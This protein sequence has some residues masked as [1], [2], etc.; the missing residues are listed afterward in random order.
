MTHLAVDVAGVDGAFVHATLDAFRRQDAAGE[1]RSAEQ[2]TADAFMEL[3]RAAAGTVGDPNARHGRPIFHIQLPAEELLAADE[4]ERLRAGN[5]HETFTGP[6]PLAELTRLIG[7]AHVA[8]LLADANG[9][10]L[11]VT[12]QKRGVPLGLWRHAV[13]RDGGCIAQG[14]DAPP[15][16]CQV[17]HLDE[18]YCDG[19]RLTPDTSGLG[20]TRH[21][22]QFDRGQLVVTWADGRPT[23][24]PPDRPTR[25]AARSTSSDTGCRASG[26]LRRRTPR[27]RRQDVPSPGQRSRPSLSRA[28][29][30][31]PR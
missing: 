11:A 8:A 23:L 26:R 13:A 1:H 19:G 4:V 21:H 2:R 6:L 24:H 30:R 14:C 29:A 28:A 7:D 9:L 20:C 16:W 25:T 5:G 22:R 18:W 10:P 12:E 15:A 3:V 17:M 27:R 31:G